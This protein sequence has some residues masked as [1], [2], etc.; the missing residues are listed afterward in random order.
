[1]YVE[2]RGRG[3]RAHVM[4]QGVRESKTFPTRQEAVDWGVSI[5]A[6]ILSGDA[7]RT[8]HTLTGALDL[9]TPANRTERI[10][11][12]VARRYAW[13]G[14]PLSDVTPAVMAAWA[15]KR[16]T[17]VSAGTVLREMSF[18]YSVF[19]RCIH[20]WQWIKVNPLKDI[21]KPAR[22]RPRDRL[23]SDAER[24]AVLE[25]LGWPADR[26]E[27]VHHEVAIAFLLALETAMRAGEILGMRWED[28]RAKTVTLMATKNGDQRQVPLSV[29]ARR[30]IELMR[31]RKLLVVRKPVDPAR[32]FHIQPATLDT[33]FR[34]ARGDQTFHFHD[35]RATAVTR[36]SQILDVRTLARMIGHRDLN[37][38]MI[39]Y[40]TTAD[41]IAELL[42]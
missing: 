28:V 33:L 7:V 14:L 13:A 9:I 17:E 40:R 41:E 27:T 20:D 16:G 39:Y 29:E 38:L 42:G 22:P 3:Y 5:E 34:R 12:G 15:A 35:A 37:S 32:V 6:A 26:V 23:I 11:I 36:L 8:R 2:K 19:R 24:D 4:R 25:A 18:L 21:T 1:M 30:L 31:G 10:R